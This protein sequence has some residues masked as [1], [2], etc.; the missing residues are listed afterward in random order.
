M[1]KPP[2]P[3]RPC[4]LKLKKVPRPKKALLGVN[5]PVESFSIP[6]TAVPAGTVRSAFTNVTAKVVG[7]TGYRVSVDL[8]AWAPTDQC[9]VGIEFRADN[10][11]VTPGCSIT[12]NGGVHHGIGG[13]VSLPSCSDPA[14]PTFQTKLEARAWVTVPS[15][16]T[17][18]GSIDL[19]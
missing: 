5:D 6:S 11:A 4:R 14:M 7:H 17:I 1:L 8:T 19:I 9:S 13:A 18:S 12:T 2:K 16:G 15:P 3:P 10:G